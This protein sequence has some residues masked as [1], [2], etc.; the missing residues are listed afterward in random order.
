MCQQFKLDVHQSKC[1]SAWLQSQEAVDCNSS[2]NSEAKFSDKY[3][4][5]KKLCTA[6]IFCPQSSRLSCGR[7]FVGTSCFPY[8][9]RIYTEPALE[10]QPISLKAEVNVL[11]ENTLDFLYCIFILNL[12]FQFFNNQL[13]VFYSQFDT[14]QIRNTPY[15]HIF[16]D[17][18]IKR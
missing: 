15:M 4:F 17:K 14:N 8:H 18:S 11:M 6:Y 12:S 7:I 3:L 13:A 5:L 1:H 16:P 2:L 10:P 9:P